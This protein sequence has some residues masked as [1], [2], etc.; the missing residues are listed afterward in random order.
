MQLV[1]RLVSLVLRTFRNATF[2]L[3]DSGPALLLPRHHLSAFSP[4]SSALL[5]S[6]SILPL[7]DTSIA[8]ELLSRDIQ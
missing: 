6:P 8:T 7:C 5:V 3:P 4:T 2:C 1:G